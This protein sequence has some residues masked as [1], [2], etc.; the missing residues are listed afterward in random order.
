VL[1]E[2][3]DVL[4]GGKHATSWS[5]LDA[6]EIS[7]ECRE[8]VTAKLQR[9]ASRQLEPGQKRELYPRAFVLTH[10]GL[11]MIERREYYCLPGGTDPRSRP[12]E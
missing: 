12:K 10:A 9:E 4:A 8:T 11:G 3:L 6:F 5:I 1:W 7:K 2:N